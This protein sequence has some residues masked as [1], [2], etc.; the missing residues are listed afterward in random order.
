[1]N[2]NPNNKH[3]FLSGE[4]NKVIACPQ[5]FKSLQVNAN[6]VVVPC[7]IDWAAKNKLGNI[8]N[9]KL[10]DIWEGDKLNE[11]RLKHLRNERSSFLPCSQCTMNE[12]SEYDSIDD[13]L[14]LIEKRLS[15]K[16]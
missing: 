4:A 10:V 14:E 3:R 16:K 9:E 6:G 8:D 2:N 15:S 11:L 7:C 12:F 5:I 1:M 13:K